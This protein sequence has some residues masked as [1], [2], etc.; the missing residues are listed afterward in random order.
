MA[1]PLQRGDA[2][3]RRVTTAGHRGIGSLHDV[4]RA[5]GRH[6][7]PPGHGRHVGGRPVCYGG[8]RR[9]SGAAPRVPAARDVRGRVDGDGLGVGGR[10]GGGRGAA[11]TQGG[12]LPARTRF[13]RPRRGPPA[14]GVRLP[15]AHAARRGRAPDARDVAE[16]R[17]RR[18]E[19]REQPPPRP[20]LVPGAGLSSPRLHG[21]RSSGD[22]PGR[23]GRPLP[24]RR[25][26]GGRAAR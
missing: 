20:A 16:R 15:F 26:P 23:R 10:P 11:A 14:A 25:S 7:R 6:S 2:R 1:R 9:G 21:P 3:P 22:P 8:R 4:E 18:P 5:R 17:D 19:P 12:P 13:G 24:T